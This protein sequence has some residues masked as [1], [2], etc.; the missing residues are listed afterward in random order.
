MK[1]L[2]YVFTTLLL[3]IGNFAIAQDF[4]VCDTEC[5]SFP[6]GDC[7]TEHT[8]TDNIEWPCEINI[9]DASIAS[10]ELTPQDLELLTGIDTPDVRPQ[11][12]GIPNFANRIVMTFADQVFAA[13]VGYKILREWTVIDWMTGTVATYIQIIKNSSGLLQDCAVLACRADLT[14]Q[15]PAGNTTPVDICL[16]LEIPVGGI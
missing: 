8:D 4:V 1:K 12:V 9:D 6:L 2:F 13:P 3:F 10:D 5:R 15:L 16:L 7:T 11:I 14:V